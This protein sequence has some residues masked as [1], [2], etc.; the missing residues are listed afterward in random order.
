MGN[1]FF[2]PTDRN[3]ARLEYKLRPED[4]ATLEGI[5]DS[6]VE[7]VTHISFF[8]ILS[9]GQKRQLWEHLSTEK[10]SRLSKLAK[11]ANREPT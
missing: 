5:V 7:G 2:L 1:T 10:R 3:L 4:L 6:I 11:G 8:E 9:K